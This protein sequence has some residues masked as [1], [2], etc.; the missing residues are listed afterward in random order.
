MRIRPLDPRLQQLVDQGLLKQDLS[1]HSWGQNFAALIEFGNIHGHC[2]VPFDTTFTCMLA[3][4]QYQGALGVWLYKLRLAKS[5]R[6]EKL[7][8]EQEALLQK[9]VDEGKFT[10][11]F[12]HRFIL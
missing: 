8:I 10:I 2:N 6:G 11:S 1:D 12:F 9:L 7:S 3:D 5:G 4:G